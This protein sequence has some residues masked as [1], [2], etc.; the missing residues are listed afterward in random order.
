MATQVVKFTYSETDGQ[1][2]QLSLLENLYPLQ[3]FPL[4]EDYRIDGGDF[5]A[6]IGYGLDTDAGDF[7]TG[8]IDVISYSYEAGDFDSGQEVFYP[9]APIIDYDTAIN[10]A[11]NYKDP[12]RYYLLDADFVPIL[13]SEI[14]R[15]EYIETSVAKAS[16]SVDLNSGFGF[17]IDILDKLFDGFDYGSVDKGF[18]YNI[19][20]GTIPSP[21]TADFDFNTI[22]NNTDPFPSSYIRS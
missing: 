19:D 12:S 17:T 20:Y 4:L 7:N 3:I 5:D 13:S 15:S 6:A 18:G 22:I 9:A 1:G 10:G 16:F 11:V 8:A 14:P 2:R 21:T